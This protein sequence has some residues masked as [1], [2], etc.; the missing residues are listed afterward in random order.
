[1]FSDIVMFYLLYTH[2]TGENKPIWVRA[3]EREEN[4]VC[5]F[6]YLY[7]NNSQNSQMLLGLKQKDYKMK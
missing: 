1:M 7:L 6:V 5:A 3:E 2:S 4:K